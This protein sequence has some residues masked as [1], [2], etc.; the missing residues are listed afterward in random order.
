MQHVRLAF[1]NHR[2]LAEDEAEALRLRSF[3]G[4]PAQEEWRRCLHQAADILEHLGWCRSALERGKRHC[5]VGAILAA[6]NEGKV[7]YLSSAQLLQT[8]ALK[9]M[10]SRSTRDLGDGAVSSDSLLM[11]WNDDVARG[12]KDVVARLRAA[13][14]N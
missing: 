9:W 1:V 13:A 12:G 10:L 4:L 2:L 14:K 3:F 8:P 6:Y 11:T 7:P 5:A